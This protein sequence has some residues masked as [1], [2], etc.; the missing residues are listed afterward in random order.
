MKAIPILFFLFVL[1]LTACDSAT[2]DYVCT[3]TYT[4]G[5]MSGSESYD[6][7]DASLDEAEADCTAYEDDL[8]GNAEC[9][10]D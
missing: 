7:T 1:T 4:V 9:T 3:C 10:L 8:G 6:I 2:S 5:S